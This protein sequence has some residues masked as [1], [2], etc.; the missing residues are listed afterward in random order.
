MLSLLFLK[1][2]QIKKVSKDTLID[3]ASQYCNLLL[4]HPASSCSE[5]LE[6]KKCGK[7]V[8]AYLFLPSGVC[9]QPHFR[10]RHMLNCHD[11]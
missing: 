10:S 5:K 7:T 1:N 4:K 6:K 3:I 9:C 11:F 2:K 8:A